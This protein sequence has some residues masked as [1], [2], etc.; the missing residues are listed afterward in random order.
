MFFF[1]PAATGCRRGGTASRGHGANNPASPRAEEV[2]R[3]RGRE[4]KEP[5]LV[6]FMRHDQVARFPHRFFALARL[7]FPPF[8]LGGDGVVFFAGVGGALFLEGGLALEGPFPAGLPLGLVPLLV[9]LD[10]RALGTSM[11]CGR[12]GG[13]RDVSARATRASRAQGHLTCP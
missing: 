13:R 11:S 5:R 3:R 12:G 2:R 9:R 10:G 8:F 4:Q 6:C 7:Y 1:N